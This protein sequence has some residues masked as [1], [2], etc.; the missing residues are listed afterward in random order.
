M[1]YVGTSTKAYEKTSDAIVE[2]QRLENDDVLMARLH[3]DWIRPLAINCERYIE[4]ILMLAQTA[5][6]EKGYKTE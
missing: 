6:Q 4:V 2:G 5:L 1:Q 3:K